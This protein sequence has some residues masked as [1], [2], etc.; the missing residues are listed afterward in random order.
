MMS[1]NNVSQFTHK[2][3]DDRRL[4]NSY[5]D[6]LLLQHLRCFLRFNFFHLHLRIYQVHN[7]PRAR[8]HF[9]KAN[10]SNWF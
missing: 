7:T 8:E 2:F 9:S 3:K 10:I 6:T 5:C 4:F 1:N